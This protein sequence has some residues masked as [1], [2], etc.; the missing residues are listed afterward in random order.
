MNT[1]EY[2]SKERRRDYERK[3]G[4]AALRSQNYDKQK[5]TKKKFSLI[6]IGKGLDM[7]FCIL[8]LILLAVGLTMMFSAS[9]PVAYYE[10][11]DSYYYLKRQLLFILIGLVLMMGISFIDYHYF[12]RMSVVVLAV[13]YFA[14]LLVL[15]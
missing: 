7:P 2:S 1:I 12:H 4:A 10:I 6:S 14:L 15:V 13:S 8:I 3:T 9:Y 5:R 11:G